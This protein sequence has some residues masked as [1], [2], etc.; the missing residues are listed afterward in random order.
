MGFSA[1]QKLKS[2]F[3]LRRR[4]VQYPVGDSVW[5]K[6]G[7]LSNAA[8]AFNA[9]LEPKFVGPFFVKRKASSVTYELKDE[10]DRS[11]PFV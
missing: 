6:N 2:R 7:V 4:Y 1:H 5:K 3:N 11:L 8:Q 10:Q 9:K